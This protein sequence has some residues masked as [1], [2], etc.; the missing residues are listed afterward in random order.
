MT[1]F[2]AAFAASVLL[3]SVRA[4]AGAPSEPR[5]CDPVLPRHIRV[6]DCRLAASIVDGL[7]RSLTLRELVDRIA[8]LDGIVYVTFEPTRPARRAP[9][10][11]ALSQRLGLSGPI[12]V[13]RVTVTRNAG[14]TAIGTVAHEFRHVTEVLEHSDARNE[15]AVYALFTRIGTQVQPGV[16]E[17]SAA[18]ESERVVLRELRASRRR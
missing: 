13:L 9:L 16:F 14:D 15:D 11:G 12:S 18:L 7:R 10:L 17:T 5:T 3:S 1:R 6:M 2:L 4:S 8:A